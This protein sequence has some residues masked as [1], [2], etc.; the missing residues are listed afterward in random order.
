M[1]DDRRRTYFMRVARET[2]LLSYA[3]KLKV[4]AVAVRD[5]RI[6]CT[7]YNGTGPGED[8]C[9]EYEVPVFLPSV[10]TGELIHINTVLKTKP[11]VTHAEKNLIDF[12]ARK[13]IALEGADL[14]CTHSP[15]MQC[16]SSIANVGFVAVYYQQTFNHEEGLN[17]LHAKRGV[18]IAQVGLPDEPLAERPASGLT[19]NPTQ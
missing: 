8:N 9:C 12:A 7:G 17:Y 3:V 14:Y 2:A 4:G 11:N 15:C 1:T 6:I 18:F 19:Q 5:G 13:G 16:A 10:L